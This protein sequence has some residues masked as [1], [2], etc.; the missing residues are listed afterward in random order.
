MCFGSGSCTIYPLIFLSVFKI[1]TFSSNISSETFS[2]NVN[3]SKSIPTYSA[4]FCFCLMYLKEEGLF[5]TKITHNFGFFDKVEISAFIS[6]YTDCATIFP[7]KII[8][9]GYYSLNFDLLYNQAII[10]QI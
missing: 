8:F 1:C 4:H 10:N 6:S 3:S 7:S 2:S 5:P 9:L